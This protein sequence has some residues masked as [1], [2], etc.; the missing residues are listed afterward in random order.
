MGRAASQFLPAL[1]TCKYV[2]GMRAERRITDLSKKRDIHTVGG[3][4]SLDRCE[5]AVL[6]LIYG[7]R[8]KVMMKSARDFI[9]L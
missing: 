3:S 5:S 7:I 2:I 9:S 8:I 4:L 1:N 6:A